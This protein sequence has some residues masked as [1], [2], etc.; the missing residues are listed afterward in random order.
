[1]VTRRHP[2][3]ADRVGE[4][5]T[6]DDVKLLT[7]KVN[8]LKRWHA[9]GALLIGDA[10]HAM[11]PIGG[12]GIN[13]AVQ[14]AAATARMLGPKLATRQPVTEADLAAVQKRRRLPAVV[15]QN[16]QRAAQRRVVDPLLHTTGRIE[17]PAPI[18]LLQRIPAL[19]VLPA[20][21]VGIGIRPEHL[22]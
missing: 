5:A 16:I 10:A 11:S 8:R 18:R 22:R 9:P 21:L 12:V 14:D 2:T 20:R 15:T 6:W 19:Q 1:Q 7:V 17:A 4:L 13:L 3:L